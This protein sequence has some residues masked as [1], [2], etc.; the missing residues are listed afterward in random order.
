[1]TKSTTMRGLSIILALALVCSMGLIALVLSNPSTAGAQPWSMYFV[2]AYEMEDS[3]TNDQIWVSIMHEDQTVTDVQLTNED[4][5]WYVEDPSVAIAPNG[6]IIVAWLRYNLSSGEFHIYYAV[7]N[8]N[9]AVVKGETVLASNDE[10]EDPC[11]AVTPDGKVFIVWEHEDGDDL[12]ACAILDSAGNILTT[13]TNITRPED[14]DDPTVGTSTKDAANNNVV[15]A[16][17]E[18]DGSPN[19]NE[20]WFTILNSSGGTVVASTQVSSSPKASEDVNVAVLPG[21]NFAIVWEVSDGSDEQ[22]WYTIRGGDGS[23]VKGNTQLTTSTEDSGEPSVAATPGGNIVIIWTEDEEDIFY[24]ILNGSGNV[25]KA[26]AQAGGLPD[27][28]NHPDVAIE[29]DGDTVI[30]WE[31]WAGTDQVVYTILGADGAIVVVNQDLTNGTYDVDLDG[32]EGRRQV[33]TKPTP[34]RPVGGEAF[35]PDKMS[36]VAPWITLAIAITVGTG[37]LVR[38]R[39]TAS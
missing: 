1:M 20:V 2:Q 4:G 6:N 13:Q 23:I 12:V 26:I 5:E 24:T 15:I 31:N 8:S 39:R 19:D 37:M 29:Q 34:L 3:S 10:N 17:E 38:R 32:G 7:L 16:W 33:A 14:V 22:I 11:V 25:V 9:G 35:S 21:G 27:T 18:G 30:S 36:V 28:D